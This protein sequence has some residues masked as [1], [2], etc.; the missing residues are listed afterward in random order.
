MTSWL[1]RY[2]WYQK[3]CPLNESILVCNK[4]T[5][6]IHQPKRR[7]CIA[8]ILY[9]LSIQFQQSW[10]VFLVFF[11]KKKRKNFTLYITMFSI[12]TQ[13]LFLTCRLKVNSTQ[14]LPGKSHW[15]KKD[16]AKEAERESAYMPG[17]ITSLV[18]FVKMLT[19][20]VPCPLSSIPAAS[21]V[22]SLEQNKVAAS[23]K[24]REE[25]GWMKEG[26]KWEGTPG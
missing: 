17:W 19:F 15:K 8:S 10:N 20:L 16:Y 18:K 13:I 23:Q 14:P 25:V 4:I 9:F 6:I 7:H 24:Q 3:G 12:R 26:W 5:S 1:G 11:L 22:P 2:A 21:D